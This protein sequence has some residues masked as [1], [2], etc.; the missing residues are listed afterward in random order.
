MNYIPRLI[1]EKFRFYIESSACIVV[2]GPKWCGKTTTSE[3]FAAKK[4]KLSDISKQKYYIQLARNDINSF[5][6]GPYPLLVD[7]WQV[8]PFIWD[9]IRFLSDEIGEFGL[10]ILTGSTAQIIQKEENYSEY[11]KVHSGTGRM[12]YL[13][14]RPLSLYESKDSLGVVSLKDL[15][16]GK[17]IKF[18]NSLNYSLRDIA[19]FICRG[20]WPLSIGKTERVALQQAIN[21]VDSL[22]DEDITKV[23][24]ENKNPARTRIL[25][26]SYSRLI[27]SEAS[28]AKIK[29]DILN[30][31]VET[32][33]DNTIISYLNTIKKLYIIEELE[34]FSL[35]LRSKTII[36]STPIRNFV[37]PSIACATLRIGPDDLLNDFNTFGLYFESMVIRDLRIYSDLMDGDVYHYRDAKNREIDAVIH[38]KDGR[39]GLCEVKLRDEDA[40][41][42]AA[43]KLIKFVKDIDTENYPKPSFLIVITAGNEAYLHE[44]GVYVVPITYL[45][46]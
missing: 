24:K 14:M 31:G 36:R 33:D 10:F 16:D 19:F 1:E 15:F 35:K 3:F 30:S 45:K 27:S 22:I 4:I 12:S 38:L 21:Y 2:K 23:S 44:D 37:D 9:Q 34:A 20:G 40:I 25:M 17:T 42:S 5:L 11:E 32:F 39:Y 13:T 26:K 43:Q 8:V 6:S 46:N 18:N 29:N 7:E 28:I 41:E